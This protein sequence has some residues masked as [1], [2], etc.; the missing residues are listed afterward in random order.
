M[1][2]VFAVLALLAVASLA[3]AFLFGSDPEGRGGLFIVAGIAGAAV[4]G[5]AALI[6]LV[7]AIFQGSN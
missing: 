2:W 4:F 7:L 5:L 1:W 6:C 3:A